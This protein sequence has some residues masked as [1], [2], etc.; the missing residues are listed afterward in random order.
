MLGRG[1]VSDRLQQA[2]VIESPDP[3]EGGKFGPL[4]RATDPVGG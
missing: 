1:N 2:L 4:G 3:L